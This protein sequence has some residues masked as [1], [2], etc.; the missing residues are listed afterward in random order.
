MKSSIPVSGTWEIETDIKIS[1][2]YECGETQ[3]G[4]SY[5]QIL[6]QPKKLARANTLAYF[7]PA[8][9]DAEE[10]FCNLETCGLYYKTITIVNDDRK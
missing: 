5:L 3:K 7:C 8:V 10:Q 6:D 1:C 4:A 2:I 9:I